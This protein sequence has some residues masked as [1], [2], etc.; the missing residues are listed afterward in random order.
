MLDHKTQCNAIVVEYTPRLNMRI[1]ADTSGINTS[2]QLVITSHLGAFCT[3]TLAI[4]A[5][6]SIKIKIAGISKVNGDILGV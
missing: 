4:N 5:M 6:M 3:A 1:I 2:I